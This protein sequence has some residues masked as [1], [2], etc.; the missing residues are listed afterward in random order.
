MS[1]KIKILYYVSFV[2]MDNTIS[3]KNQLSDIVLHCHFSHSFCVMI[4]PLFPK[5]FLLLRLKI[6]VWV[7]VSGRR[8]GT[9]CLLIQI[10]EFTLCSTVLRICLLKSF[11]LKFI[12]FLHS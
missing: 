8:R 1:D 7:D 3:H 11:I 9:P 4:H 12:M 10:K 5:L 6:F 2:I